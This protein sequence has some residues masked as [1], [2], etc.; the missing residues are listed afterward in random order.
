MLNKYYKTIYNSIFITINCYIKIVKYIFI[1]IRINIVELTKIFFNKTVL[2]F[3]ILAIIISNKKSIF[4]SI[5]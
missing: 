3:E 1:T 4:T 5:F 2:Y